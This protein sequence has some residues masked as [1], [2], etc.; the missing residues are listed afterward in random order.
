MLRGDFQARLC[1][2]ERSSL[3][4]PTDYQL[5][6][7]NGK[8]LSVSEERANKSIGANKGQKILVHCNFK[9]R[10]VAICGALLAIP[11][12][13]TVA[14]RGP[15]APPTKGGDQ[16]TSRTRVGSRARNLQESRCQAIG[17]D[18]I[19]ITCEYGHARHAGNDATHPSPVMIN[20]AELSFEP[21]DSSTLRVTLSF[22]NTGAAAI[23][24]ARAVYIA[25][26]DNA[27]NNYVRR[28]LPSVDFR[29]LEPGK[30]TTFTEQLR[31]A[32]FPPGR[33]TIALWIPST[34]KALQFDPAHNLMVDGAGVAD[35]KSGLNVLAKF[36]V[37][38]RQR[39][40]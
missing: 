10:F 36:T 21:N 4:L 37:E 7:G 31:V 28:A 30:P 34:D 38:D 29:K 40:K 20:R 25:I 14:Q 27:G 12:L 35:A 18:E 1:R 16:K 26:D 19:T 8:P 23:A 15:V 5:E 11:A 17:D 3:H 22:T 6:D 32:K 2:G 33:Y 24:E 9:M 39:R 13:M